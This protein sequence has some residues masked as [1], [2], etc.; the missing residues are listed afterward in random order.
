MKKKITFRIVLLFVVFSFFSCISYHFMIKGQLY[1]R[2][3]RFQEKEKGTKEIHIVYHPKK[4]II[5]NESKNIKINYSWLDTDVIVPGNEMA[6]LNIKKNIEEEMTLEEDIK[7]KIF[8]LPVKNKEYNLDKEMEVLYKN[9]HILSFSYHLMGEVEQQFLNQIKVVSLNINTGTR[10]KYHDISSNSKKLKQVIKEYLIREIKNQQLNDEQIKNKI[11]QEIE[12][13][14]FYLDDTSL[15]LVMDIC[16]E[17]D[18]INKNR[19]IKIPYEKI[20]DLLID[21][22]YQEGL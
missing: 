9:H 5:K 20:N 8:S 10:L 7:D 14:N 18:S 13:E 11:A 2:K 1:T 22:Y 15:V 19:S 21:K 12:K 17:A 4:E 6:S 16:D 3:I